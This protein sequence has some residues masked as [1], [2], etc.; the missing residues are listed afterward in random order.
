MLLVE[1]L[2]LALGGRT[3]LN[4]ITFELRPGE[5]VGL[6]GVNGAGKTSLLKIL[7]GQSLPDNGTVLAPENFSYLPQEPRVAF[8]PGQTA[9][10]CLLDARGLLQL[11]R[12]M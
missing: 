12:E 8:S 4:E 1:N 10:E 2:S 11:A 5:K 6:V 7:A 3:I 9:L